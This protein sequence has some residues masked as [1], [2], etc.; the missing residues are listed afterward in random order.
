MYFVTYEHWFNKYGNVA[1]D[2]S[3][4]D[5]FF[6]SVILSALWLCTKVV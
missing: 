6:C 5:I 2:I 3:F 1:I 4:N